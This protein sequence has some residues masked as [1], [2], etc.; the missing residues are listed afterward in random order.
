M[1]CPICGEEHKHLIQQ[2][3]LPT[4]WMLLREMEHEQPGWLPEQGACN[5]CLDAAHIDCFL[6]AQEHWRGNGKPGEVDGYLILPTPVRLSADPALSGKGVTICMI[7]SGFYPHPD[8]VMPE[9]RV[10]EMLDITQPHQ[11]LAHFFEAGPNAWHG[12]M[13]SVVCAGNGFLSKGKYKGIASDANLVLLKVS[14]E[15][16]RIR[17]EN[18]VKALEW[19]IEHREQHNI[20]IINLSVTDD[21]PEPWRE[22]RV[23]QWVQKVVEAGIVVVAA[24]G[25]DPTAELLPPASSPHAITVGG[26]NDRNTLHPLVN[27][28]YHSTFGLSADGL[29]KPDLI[30]PAVWVAAPVL[31]GTAE[32]QKALV[33]FD[34]WET[35]DAFLAPKLAN[36]L[37]YSGLDAGLLDKSTL[38]IR[39]AIKREIARAKLINPHYQHAD[40]TSFAAPIVC[41]IIAQMLEADPDLSP[42]DMREILL[43][44]AR[45]LPGATADRQ[46]F[47]VVHAPG[48]TAIA[49]ERDIPVMAGFTPAINYREGFVAF[50]F[51]GEPRASVAASGDFN[52]WSERHAALQKKSGEKGIWKGRI[53]LPPAGT[54][55][56]KFIIDQAVWK[57]DPANPF[58]E[59][60]GFGGFNSQLIVE[61]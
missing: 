49:S 8:L 58:R 52:G 19:A 5:R 54:Y 41:S 7:D 34:L 32:H 60:D 12:T 22:N 50:Q 1:K 35:D 29:Q 25:N 57:P 16:G 18:I 44:T 17:G 39:E 6:R 28:L 47:G 30:A 42:V 37:Q 10:L 3:N 36:M 55:R 48:A 2:F 14:D 51:R 27:A 56:Y 43:S 11:P 15:A 38:E 23:S 21:A 24:A 46:G 33:L 26:L 4:D 20:R 31:P 53:P 13:T 40:G 9:N 61:Q 59:P 45:P